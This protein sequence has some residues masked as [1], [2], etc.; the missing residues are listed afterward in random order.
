M[1]EWNTGKARLERKEGVVILGVGLVG[2][3]I[4]DR[5]RMGWN[6]NRIKSSQGIGNGNGGLDWECW[7]GRRQAGV[8]LI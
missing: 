8:D 5:A 3:L 4:G 2:R 1:Q 6:R 7:I